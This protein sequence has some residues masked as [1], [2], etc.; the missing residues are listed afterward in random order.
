[1]FDDELA[2]CLSDSRLFFGDL[3]ILIV[4]EVELVLRDSE[5]DPDASAGTRSL[6][7]SVDENRQ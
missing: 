1:M 5:I 7:S 6:Y 2:K 4:G 3:V